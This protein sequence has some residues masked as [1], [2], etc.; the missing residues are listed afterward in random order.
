M[1]NSFGKSQT[2]CSRLERKTEISQSNHLKQWRAQ[3][4]VTCVD[5]LLL[6]LL[7]GEG[8]HC[9][10]E[11]WPKINPSNS[12]ITVRFVNFWLATGT[13]AGYYGDLAP[14]WEG[15]RNYSKDHKLASHSFLGVI[16]QEIF[17][18]CSLTD[19]FEH[20]YIPHHIYALEKSSFQQL[21]LIL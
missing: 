13:A 5:L 10:Q 18:C 3:L 19:M 7:L 16:F 17:T 6:S 12:P 20:Q 14:S 21:N 1:W 15:E 9:W 11:K 2:P 4:C 8:H